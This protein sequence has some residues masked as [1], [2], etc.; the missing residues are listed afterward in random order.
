MS[1]IFL[2]V[3]QVPVRQGICL[4]LADDLAELLA[5]LVL[6]DLTLVDG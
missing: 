5:L 1:A 3:L 6:R 2:D 4:L